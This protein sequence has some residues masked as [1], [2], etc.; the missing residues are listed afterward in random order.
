MIEPKKILNKEEIE[1]LSLAYLKMKSNPQYIKLSKELHDW[2]D[3]FLDN[4][5]LEIKKVKGE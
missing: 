2:M 3:E 1:W 5:L 4:E